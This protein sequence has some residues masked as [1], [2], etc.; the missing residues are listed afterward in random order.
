MIHFLFELDLLEFGHYMLFL[1][2]LC[3]LAANP[4]V[5]F[6]IPGSTKSSE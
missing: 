1:D 3:G 6:S 4:E 5:S 2:R